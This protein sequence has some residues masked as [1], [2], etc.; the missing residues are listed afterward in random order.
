LFRGNSGEFSTENQA[1]GFQPEQGFVDIGG[2]NCKRSLILEESV[3]S[4]YGLAHGR[5]C[6]LFIQ[7]WIF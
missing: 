6:H 7:H 5:T 4:L 2:R 1:A 3:T